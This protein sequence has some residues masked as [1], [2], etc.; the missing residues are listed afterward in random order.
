MPPTH[1]P[2]H[3]APEVLREL[4]QLEAND[5][6]LQR[7]DGAGPDR[8]L[9]LEAQVAHLQEALLTQRQIG[10]VIG[11]VAQRFG[12]TTHQAW[13]VL[14]RLSQNTNIKVRVVA[15]VL[16]EAFDGQGRPEDA[17]LL[18]Q[19]AAHLPASGWPGVKRQDDQ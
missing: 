10:A 5:L 18:T 14:V 3:V 2:T 1:T 6:D 13:R 8:I 16:C 9:Q 11:M 17:R 4:G 15:R 12:C 7:S 19:L